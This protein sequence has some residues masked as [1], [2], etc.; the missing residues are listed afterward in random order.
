MVGHGGASDREV[1]LTNGSYLGISIVE[2]DENQ[3]LAKTYRRGATCSCLQNGGLDLDKLAL[4][5]E[6]AD[7]LDHLDMHVVRRR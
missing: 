2:N 5:E 3:G 7:V 1:K 4:V 6:I